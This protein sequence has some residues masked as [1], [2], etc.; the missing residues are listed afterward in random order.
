MLHLALRM[1]RHR[2]AALLAVACAA[3]GG[4][5]F[6]TGIG[7]LAESGFRSHAP[8]ERLTRADVVVSAA[9]TY[10]PKGGLAIGLPERARVPRELT[11]RLARLPGVT[12]AVGDVSFPA[13]VLDRHGAVLSTGDTGDPAV[14]GHGWSST[15][16]L[17]HPRVS[18]AAPAGPGDVALD[19]RTAAAAGV[20]PG[21]Q[22]TVVAAG[23]RATYRVSAVIGAADG[24]V[25][26][27][28]ATAANLGG[29]GRV[30]LVALR[31]APAP[32]T[33][34]RSG[35]VPSRVR[36]G[37]SCP[38]GR[39]GVTSSPPTRW[40]GAACCPCWPARSPG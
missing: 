19:T 30:D 6:V 3:L 28:D 21:G 5:A 18:G 38:P 11:A 1:A 25:F 34:S 17:D 12:A 15:G 14:A 13:A 31:T 4:A 24:G 36:P 35:P 33:P 10:H 16:L 8:V 40:P 27:T 23:R 39:R 2:I 22:V 29:R 20:A 32:A 7:V 37:W 9:Q 26:F